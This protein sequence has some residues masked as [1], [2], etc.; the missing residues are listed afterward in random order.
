MLPRM[1]HSHSRTRC[2]LAMRLAFSHCLQLLLPSFFPANS[3]VPH[4]LTPSPSSLA[5]SPRQLGTTMRH[6]WVL[7]NQ[8]GRCD[9]CR[10]AASGPL[11]FCLW[12]KSQVHAICRFGTPSGCRYGRHALSTLVVSVA[13]ESKLG[14]DKVCCLFPVY[15]FLSSLFKSLSVGVSQALS[16]SVDLPLS[17]FFVFSISLC[18][19]TY[20][21]IPHPSPPPPG[22][23]SPALLS[24]STANRRCAGQHCQRRRQLADRMESECASCILL[25]LAADNASSPSFLVT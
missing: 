1:Q 11:Y 15:I 3:S 17:P 9:A 7:R 4:C 24:P 2:L 14:A 16:I 8:P 5:L 20:T 21:Y 6:Q 22:P 13:E 18:L 10:R 23:F 25:T 12:C 19:Y